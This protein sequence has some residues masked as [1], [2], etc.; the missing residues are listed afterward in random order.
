[1]IRRGAL[2]G[3]AFLL[4]GGCSDA[5]EQPR[6]AETIASDEADVEE[7]ARTLEEAADE[8]AAIIERDLQGEP[9]SSAD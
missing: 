9:V 4:V 8:A 5:R 3:A 1:M 2:A 7:D 6:T